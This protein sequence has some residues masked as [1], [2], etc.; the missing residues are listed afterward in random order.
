MRQ[1]GYSPP[2]ERDI[3]NPDISTEPY[4]ITHT[5]LDIIRG[6]PKSNTKIGEGAVFM[7]G[8]NG[9]IVNKVIEV[10]EEGWIVQLHE[11]VPDAEIPL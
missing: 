11:R 6:N 4:L 10:T 2:G 3:Y 5:H 7:Q 8:D 1:V 9:Y